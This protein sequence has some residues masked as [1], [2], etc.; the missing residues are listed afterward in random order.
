ML[1]PV[2]ELT[3]HRSRDQNANHLSTN[4][5]LLIFE[6]IRNAYLTNI[7]NDNNCNSIFL[8]IQIK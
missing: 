3:T 8:T 7:R 6:I 4:G 2:F 1:G 5:H